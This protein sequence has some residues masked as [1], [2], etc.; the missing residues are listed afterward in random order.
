MTV[1]TLALWALVIVPILPAA[2]SIVLVRNWRTDSVV[3]HERTVIAFRDWGAASLAALLALEHLLSWGWPTW[4][5][6]ATMYTILIL[7]SLPSAW[8]LYLYLSGN[9]IPDPPSSHETEEQA[10]DR[11]FGDQRRELRD[12][13]VEQAV[14]EDRRE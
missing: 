8:W 6:I 7:A 14:E 4:L 1:E 10:E 9:F 2:A 3:L 13:A 5:W 11:H 12:T